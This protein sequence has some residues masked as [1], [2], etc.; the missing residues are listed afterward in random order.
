MQSTRNSLIELFSTEK[1]QHTAGF[2]QLCFAKI[3]FTGQYT[4]LQY[5]IK[6]LEDLFTEIKSIFITL[7]AKC[8]SKCWW[9]TVKH[10][11][12]PFLLV[13][14]LLEYLKKRRGLGWSKQYKQ[15]V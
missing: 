2:L 12:L 13:L 15:N 5:Q 11:D 8:P 10:S 9:T 7:V 1:G 6:G 3:W 4:V 14:Q